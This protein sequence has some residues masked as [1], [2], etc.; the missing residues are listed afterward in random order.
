MPEAPAFSDRA[1]SVDEY[2]GL[3][4]A[5]GM[6]AYTPEAARIGLANGLHAVW[7]R[8]EAGRLIGMGRLVGDG[9][10][11]AQVT[12]I[13]VHP[14]WQRRG[15]GGRIMTA[16]MDWAA[17]QLPSGCYISLIADPGAE[18]L[19]QKH[20]FDFRTGMARRMA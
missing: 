3:R 5:A 13:A 16:L 19:Y 2:L 10:C 8:D 1:A 9:G 17:G 6:G 12:D 18:A 15:L 4:A 20:G 11:F 14:D 7:L